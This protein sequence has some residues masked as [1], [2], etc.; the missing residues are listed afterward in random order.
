M[1][2]FIERLL[3]HLS[4]AMLLGFAVLAI[5]D[6]YNPLMRFLTSSTSKV[7]IIIMCVISLISLVMYAA[8]LNRE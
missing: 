8:K 3:P 4:I 5:L 2:R 6:S 7:Y 1:R